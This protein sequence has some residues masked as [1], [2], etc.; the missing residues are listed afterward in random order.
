MRRITVS[1]SVVAAF[2]IVCF[3]LRPRSDDLWREDVVSCADTYA[4]DPPC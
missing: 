3:V 2:A 4:P 1:P